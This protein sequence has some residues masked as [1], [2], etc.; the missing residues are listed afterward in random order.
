[1]ER[2]RK[3]LHDLSQNLKNQNKT[4]KLIE[5]RLVIIRGRG[6]GREKW[7]KGVYRQKEVIFKSNQ[8]NMSSTRTYTIHVKKLRF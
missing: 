6:E 2:E 3:I 5:K 4:S 7:V 8:I 1:M